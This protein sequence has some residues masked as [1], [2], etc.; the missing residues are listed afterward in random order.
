MN[1]L[2]RERVVELLNRVAKRD[3]SA[4]SILYQHY[5]K[6]IF[7]YVYRKVHNEASADEITVDTFFVAFSKP[8]QYDG[9]CEF[10]TWL[11]GIAKYKILDFIRSTTE[12]YGTEVPGD[13]EAL[14]R[15]SPPVEDALA[16]LASK[17]GT[18]MIMICIDKLPRPQREA[19][20]LVALD[21]D[22]VG[23]IAIK[24]AIPDGTVKSRLFHA[25]EKLIRCLSA[26]RGDEM[27]RKFNA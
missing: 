27:K 8:Q 10:S 4:S 15:A 25:R 21:E 1:N 14:S 26:M 9:M 23:E 7:A 12:L 11:C 19:M 13:E 6:Q 20:Y 24:M 3:D 5:Q 22:S 18:Q 17:E 2:S 16:G